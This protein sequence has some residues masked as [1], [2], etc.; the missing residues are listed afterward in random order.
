MSQP[1]SVEFGD[2]A[3]P[4]SVTVRA[5]G[6][7]IELIA[8]DDGSLFIS[9]D[10]VDRHQQAVV[11]HAAMDRYTVRCPS[12]RLEAVQRPAGTKP[13]GTK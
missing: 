12:F 9:A 1:L 5:N 3:V 11:Q 8:N 7:E 13:A 2:E 10:A 6:L 4:K